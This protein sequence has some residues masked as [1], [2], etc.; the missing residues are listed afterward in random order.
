CPQC[1]V[2][3]EPKLQARRRRMEILGGGAV[4]VALLV[5]GLMLLKHRH[6]TYARVDELRT[7]QEG[8]GTHNDETQQRFFRLYKEH[9]NDAG[10][11]YLW[12]RCVEDDDG[13]Q[14]DLAQ[15]GIRADPG[16]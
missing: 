8:L 12:A 5:G 10:Y 15:E 1:G 4:L 14:F 11:I 6:I 2:P 9:P 13:K 7:E 16:F 3:L